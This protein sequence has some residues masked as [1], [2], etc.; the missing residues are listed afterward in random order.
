MLSSNHYSDGLVKISGDG[1]LTAIASPWAVLARSLRRSNPEEA[2]ATG[3]LRRKL[4]A[5][6]APGGKVKYLSPA[7][8]V[9]KQR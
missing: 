5:R 7:G 6:T 4:L 8:R 1:Y 9:I 2:W 3:L